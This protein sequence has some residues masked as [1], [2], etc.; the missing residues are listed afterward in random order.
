MRPIDPVE[1]A[2]APTMGG[3]A[4]VSEAV[5]RALRARLGDTSSHAPARPRDPAP[6]RAA[7]RFNRLWLTPSFRFFMRRIAPVLAI[8]GCVGLWFADADN[9][10][11][12][13]DTVAEVKRDIQNRPEFMVK[14][15]AIDGASGE[16][17][18]DIREITS[19]D[20]PLSSFD[21]DLPGMLE[22]IES[23]D[24]VAEAGLRV[25]AGGIL[26]IDITERT[27]AVVWRGPHGLEMLDVDGHRVAAL[28]HRVDRP[29]LPLI[30]GVGA[31]RDVAEAL[32][33]LNAAKP[34]MPR[35]RGLVRVGERRW[36]VVLDR[37]QVIMLPEENPLGAMAQVMAL[38]QAKD[39]LG[40][41]VKAVD[42]RRPN[43]PTLQL[44][45]AAQDEMRRLQS[46]ELGVSF[47]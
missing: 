12:F 3:S 23:L 25:R 39:L 5:A 6:S 7:Y 22:Q 27:P 35:L 9:R 4:R 26:Q 20:F 36:N 17:S 34:I 44:T 1:F 21:L 30:A 28:E 13:N 43:R 41:D 2:K 31:E 33:I 38:D 19:L 14:L 37:D 29:D 45:E 8:A 24:A 46:V 15:M 42:M 16:L 40:R 18:E 11:A 10:M 32:A 47:R